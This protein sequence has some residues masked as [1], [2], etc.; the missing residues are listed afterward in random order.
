LRAQLR[1]RP[2]PP[3]G[4]KPYRDIYIGNL[5]EGTTGPQLQEALCA[6]LAQMGLVNG[7]G[8]PIT[9]TWVSG[10]GHYAFCEFRTIEEANNATKLNGI[11]L[12][13]STIKVGRPKNYA[14]P[15]NPDSATVAALLNGQPIPASAAAAPPAPP[16]PVALAQQLA[17][18]TNP[19]VPCPCPPGS[20][21][22]R[23]RTCW[24]AWP[25]SP[26]P[27]PRRCQC[28]AFSWEAEGRSRRTA[29]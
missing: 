8:E 13:T 25:A 20:P 1:L 11:V 16:D 21:P 2:P 24:A 15:A 14:G 5:P 19:T 17:A 27:P 28:L 12:G 7:P 10:D 18:Q 23:P 3:G 29:C 22:A 4:R 26:A 6:L 9:S